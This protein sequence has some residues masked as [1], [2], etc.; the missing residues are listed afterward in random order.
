MM[1]PAVRYKAGAARSSFARQR[2]DKRGTYTADGDNTY[3]QATGW[4]SNTTFPCTIFSNKLKVVGAGTV[5][6]AWKLTSNNAIRIMRNGV[7]VAVPTS[8]VTGSTPLTVANGDL[9]HVEVFMAFYPDTT[10]SAGGFIEVY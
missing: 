10:L 3:V 4:A 8:G 1:M 5:T 9:L 2:M 6:L 7:Q